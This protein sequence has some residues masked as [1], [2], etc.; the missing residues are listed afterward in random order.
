M[1]SFLLLRDFFS[2]GLWRD[3]LTELPA[4]RRLFLG[5]LR[6]LILTAREFR[7]GLFSL[8]AMSLVYTTLLSLVP[9]L[10][11]VFSTLKAFGFHNRVEPLIL[12]FL[13]PL[14]ERGVE[15]TGRIISFIDHLKVGVLGAVGILAFFLSVISLMEKIEGAMNHIWR[16][17]EMR[18]LPRRFSD[19]L[20]V[21]VVGPLLLFSSLGAL[22][23][24]RRSAVVQQ[25]L[26]IEPWG[27]LVALV[28]RYIPYVG[29]SLAF[30]FLYLFIPNTRVRFPSALI[31]GMAGGLLWLL[32][33][34]VFASFVASTARYDLVYSSFASLILFFLWL[35]VAWTIILVGAEVAYF[36][37]NPQALT[38]RRRRHYRIP[39]VQEA[40]ALSVMREIARA[41]L[42]GDP[43]P[44]I[45]D[46]A[47]CLGVPET[48][49]RYVVDRQRDAGLL[50]E[51]SAQPPGLLP[52]VSPEN[53]SLKRILDAAR[54][55]APGS[56]ASP[57]SGCRDEEGRIEDL[58]ARIDE[59]IERAVEGESLKD[60]ASGDK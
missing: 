28:T 30:A 52:S 58:T 31:G 14:G 43:P 1:K 13:S 25:I 47:R 21:I 8:R 24:V 59:A 44:T 9:L 2:T 57:R 46:L 50:E 41:F 4:P 56:T 35:Y 55:G 34:W 15:I 49:V 23:T 45:W 3:N 32:S 5:F 27:E 60:L 38:L 36:H 48:E 33:G 7:E 12:E 51:N 18:S 42:R 6:L 40:L 54:G 19:Y 16:V 20:S 29:I 17:R 39:A 22:A 26:A 53:T 11:V 37:Q 10:A